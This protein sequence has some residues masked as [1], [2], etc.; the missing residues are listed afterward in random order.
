MNSDALLKYHRLIADGKTG[1]AA[2]LMAVEF[3]SG[4]WLAGEFP[5]DRYSSSWERDRKMKEGIRIA[6]GYYEQAREACSGVNKLRAQVGLFR[7]KYGEL[8][9]NYPE[10]TP[11]AR[12]RRERSL[13]DKLLERWSP[14]FRS[15]IQRV[16]DRSCGA[17][18]CLEALAA[19]LGLEGSIPSKQIESMYEV[20]VRNGSAAACFRLGNLKLLQKRDSDAERYFRMGVMRGSLESERALGELLVRAGNQDEGIDCLVRTADKGSGEAWLSMAGVFLSSE[21]KT[22]ESADV[23]SCYR[24][25]ARCGCAAAYDWLAERDPVDAKDRYGFRSTRER[26]I[27]E[28]NRRKWETQIAA[29]NADLCYMAYKGLLG[30]R[31]YNHADALRRAVERAA[32]M[33]CR[34]AMF[35]LALMLDSDAKK[36][37]DDCGCSRQDVERCQGK[38]DVAAVGFYRRA[39]EMGHAAAMRIVGCLYRDGRVFAAD[40]QQAYGWMLKAAVAGDAEAQLIVAGMFRE[41]MGCTVNMAEAFTWYSKAYGN[42]GL[43]KCDASLAASG[44][45]HFGQMMEQLNEGHPDWN[46]VLAVYKRAAEEFKSP[47]AYWRLGELYESGLCGSY[48]LDLAAKNYC[49]ALFLRGERRYSLN[50]PQSLFD[51]LS[52]KNRRHKDENAVSE[53]SA[54]CIVLAYGYDVGFYSCDE[55]GSAILTPDAKKARKWYG[56]AKDYGCTTAAWRYGEMCEFGLGGPVDLGVAESSYCDA[57]ATERLEMT[58]LLASKYKSGVIGGGRSLELAARWLQKCIDLGDC[59]SAYILGNLHLTGS[60]VALDKLRA[61]ELF[62]QSKCGAGYMAIAKICLEGDGSGKDLD[63]ALKCLNHCDSCEARLLLGKLCYERGRRFESGKGVEKNF[64]EA[65][66]W[67]WKAAC[68]KCVEAQVRLSDL[69]ERGANGISRNLYLASRWSYWASENGDARSAFRLG[70]Y[71]ELGFVENEHGTS[72]VRQLYE[73]AK[74]AGCEKAKLRLA[75]VG[76]ALDEVLPDASDCPCQPDVEMVDN[77]SCVA[78]TERLIDSEIVRYA[79]GKSRNTAWIR[80]VNQSETLKRYVEEHDICELDVP[81]RKFSIVFNETRKKIEP[82]Y[83]DY[84]DNDYRDDYDDYMPRTFEDAYEI[85]GSRLWDA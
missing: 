40:Q 58:K 76:N 18:Q 25:A 34:D 60:G 74:R 30:L 29:C 66:R 68:A 62:T 78:R 65:V 64:L 26:L 5:K 11:D 28:Y 31:N 56:L 42:D 83:E 53:Q 50:Q 13:C 20:A 51:D 67:Y 45:W 16:R 14:D 15:R 59:E 33:G 70:V 27:A 61:I 2:L 47:E 32:I 3:E 17:V 63:L 10:I 1:D 43:S 72:Y 57:V 49:N 81:Q 71:C 73:K 84:D 36:G 80:K 55:E 24:F 21:D 23:A 52:Q 6:L 4:E 39:A 75:E 69:Y 44:C 7:C 77:V 54:Y 37:E 12:L 48:S 41:G 46:S 8:I 22:D 35:E 9:Y 38:D 79:F 19:D 82:Y 85:Y